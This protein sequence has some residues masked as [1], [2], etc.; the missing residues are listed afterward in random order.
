[1]IERAVERP[2]DGKKLPTDSGLTFTIYSIW[3]VKIFL[4]YKGKTE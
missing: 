3:T 2:L 4:I 1:M